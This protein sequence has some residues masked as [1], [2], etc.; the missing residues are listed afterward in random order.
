VKVSDLPP[1]EDLAT[2]RKQMIDTLVSHGAR[3]QL[4]TGN[5]VTGGLFVAI[6]FFPDAPPATVDWSQHP[7]ELPT[8]P[9]ELEAIEA[10]VVNIIKKL[11]ALPLKAIGDDL[12]KAMGDLDRTLVSARVTFDNAGRLVQPDSTLDTDLTN[13][14]GEVSRA[15]QG[16]RIL[17]D[18]LERHPE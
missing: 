18:Y 4:R 11:D 5:L 6:D 2:I 12:Q 16:I 9:G 13:T 15:A 3:A 10:S 1:G 17:A 7:V 8:I 14:L